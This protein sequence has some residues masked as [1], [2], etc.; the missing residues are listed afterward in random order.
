MYLALSWIWVPNPPLLQTQMP[1]MPTAT[2]K[3][4]QQKANTFRVLCVWAVFAVVHHLLRASDVKHIL[5]L[6]WGRV[7]LWKEYRNEGAAR[8]HVL[9][10]WLLVSVDRSQKKMQF[11]TRA[12][13][14]QKW[15]LKPLGLHATVEVRMR[16]QGEN[17]VCAQCCCCLLSW[18]GREVWEPAGTAPRRSRPSEEFL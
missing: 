3:R 2:S 18:A 6:P 1:I 11:T 17:T 13:L 16:S 5:L 12:V 10:Q 15:R 8:S 4:K 14:S 7:S 9:Q